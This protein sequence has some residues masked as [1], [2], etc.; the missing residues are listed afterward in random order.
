PRWVRFQECCLTQIGVW[1]TLPEVLDAHGDAWPEQKVWAAMIH[2]A[3][4]EATF[5]EPAMPDASL[6]GVVWD[7]T[8]RLLTNPK[9]RT[10][11]KEQL[12]EGKVWI[13]SAYYYVRAEELSY[14]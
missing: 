2:H 3:H 12:L 8:C 11:K 6:W 13:D 14:R 5:V 10:E 7:W 9:L 4:Q 1:P